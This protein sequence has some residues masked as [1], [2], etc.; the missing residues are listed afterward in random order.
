MGNAAMALGV[1]EQ[2]G[3]SK[4]LADRILNVVLFITVLTSS[5]AFIEPSPT[6]ALMFVLLVACV[7]ARVRFDRKLAPLLVLIVLWLVGGSIATI[8]DDDTKAYQFLG[9]SAYLDISC[10]MIACLYCDGDLVRLAILRRA[11]LIAAL[12]AVVAGY[13]GW[14]HLL[15]VY[16]SFLLN[17][18]VAGTF[19]DPNVFGPFLIFPLGV[20]G[21]L[22]KYHQNPK[23]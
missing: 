10:V 20:Q 11:Y 1:A 6:D 23:L 8:V 7:L 9:T 19:K 2:R 14:F 16:N 3:G 21:Y 5:I 15:P 12:I 17:G 22:N 4:A 13:I 18:R